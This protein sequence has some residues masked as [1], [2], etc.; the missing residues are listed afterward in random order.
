MVTAQIIMTILINAR[1]TD[2]YLSGL[3]IHIH[4]MMFK[5]FLC[6]LYQLLESLILSVHSYVPGEWSYI[7]TY[8]Y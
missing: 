1:S 7:R 5:G 6:D 3:I 2:T 4:G 8:L